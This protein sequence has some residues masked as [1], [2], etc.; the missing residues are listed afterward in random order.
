MTDVHSPEPREGNGDD[1]QQSDR[2]FLELHWEGSRFKDVQFPVSVAKELSTI[3]SAV[4]S[5]ARE[6]YLRK[7]SGRQR[8]PKGF[9]DS[10]GLYLDDIKEGCVNTV[11]VDKPVRSSEATLFEISH[12][13]YFD[14]A[15]DLFLRV[16]S[17]N[18]STEEAQKFKSLEEVLSFGKSLE[19]GD[20]VTLIPT[21]KTKSAKVTFTK[22]SRTRT[23]QKYGV[24]NESE[25]CSFIGWLKN[26]DDRGEVSFATYSGTN[27]S[28][29]GLVTGK[30]WDDCR[31]WM[32]R[33]DRAQPL[34]IEGIFSV[35]NDGK[36]RKVERIDALQEA[37]PGYWLERVNY[38][39]SLED[40]WLGDG[41][42]K[43]ATSLA[44]KVVDCLLINFNDSE[45]FDPGDRP[46]IYPLVAGGFQLEW[47]KYGQDWSIE[48]NNDGR[49]EVDA[50]GEGDDIDK[51]IPSTG[52]PEEIAHR[53]FSIVEDGQDLDRK[54]NN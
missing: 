26:L 18:A 32:D 54:V 24:T 33:E 43:A 46:G 1:H 52:S 7:H 16:I 28:L 17:G 39:M 34:Q 4:K 30:L 3:E 23:R 2:N 19:E 11:L 48:I 36:V 40:G 35:S 27:I 8:V 37:Y 41:E 9:L 22:E 45:I 31:K 14:E 50:I 49:V 20:E 15:L 10:F 13:E 51:E 53:A 25:F 6:I 29:G 21:P 5:L 12:K 42:G 47:E 38:V 44:K